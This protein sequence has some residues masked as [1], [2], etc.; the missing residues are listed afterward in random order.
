MSLFQV[1]GH[2]SYNDLSEPSCSL[3]PLDLIV[4]ILLAWAWFRWSMPQVPSTTTCGLTLY[5]SMM[6]TH[7]RKGPL[8][9]CGCYSIA[10]HASQVV[11]QL[12]CSLPY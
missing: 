9:S 4:P 5:Q 12:L 1:E 10:Q 8:R 2:S 7:L 3:S 11:S 6:A